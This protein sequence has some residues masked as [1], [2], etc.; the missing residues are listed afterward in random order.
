MIGAAPKIGGSDGDSA[1]LLDVIAQYN[2]LQSFGR[3][4]P[5]LRGFTGLGLG[6]WFT[7]GDTEDDSG[8]SDLDIIANIGVRIL[9][10]PNMSIFL[11]MRNA[12]DE[13]DSISEYGRFGA[14]VR[15]QF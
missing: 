11:E 10:N 3:S 7:S 14:G 2:W 8:D 1:F 15:F 9:D 4:L 5:T 6:G 12:V 13:L